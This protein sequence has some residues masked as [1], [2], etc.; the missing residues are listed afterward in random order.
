MKAAT[1]NSFLLGL[2]RELEFGVPDETA[3]LE[4]VKA[5]LPANLDF[6]R[7]ESPGGEVN[8]SGY[9]EPGVP[10]PVTGPVDFGAR[11]SAAN[12]LLFAEHIF[13]KVT[14][15][16]LATG[17]Y[18]YVV[19]PDNEA[20]GTSLFAVKA[21]PPVELLRYYGMRLSG[22]TMQIGNNTAIPVRFP[23]FVSHGCRLSPATED[24]VTGT[25]AYAPTLRGLLKN[26]AAGD[27]YLR[28]TQVS[29]VV[30]VKFE[31]TTGTPTFAGSS[32]VT[33]LYD[34]STGRAFYQNAISDAGLDLGIWDE[35]YDP[36]EYILPG[37]ATDHADLAVGDTWKFEVDWDEP[38]VA[39][40]V[41][42][43]YTS[44]H[45]KNRFREVGGSTWDEFNSLTSQFSF[46]WPLSVDQGSG[47]KYYFGLDRDQILNTTAQLTRKLIDLD[48]SRWKEEHKRFEAQFGWYGRQLSAAYR[49]SVVIDVPSASLGNRTAPVANPNAVVETLPLTFE[50]N[51]TLDPPLTMTIITDRDFT[52]AT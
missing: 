18:Q 38:A 24:T 6:S 45:Q 33:V 16:T 26:P 44:A 47:S 2:G 28:V 22:M 36:L 40:V 52:V 51:A 10:G 43:R 12:L 19:E 42:K 8:P 46:L 31:Q 48:F 20:E 35:N 27:V 13:K 30:I 29:P 39:Y 7:P 15:S 41:G 5:M 4:W 14:K 49:E 17:I 25:Y 34:P 32:T 21:V 9:H 1:G 3:S 23:G 37:T 50:T 11:F